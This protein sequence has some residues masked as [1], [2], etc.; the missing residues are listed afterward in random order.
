MRALYTSA[1]GMMAQQ[2]NLDV[3]ANNLA[4]VNT[5]G[6]KRTAAHF[7]DLIYQNL[8]TPGATSD[9]GT[10]L[11][12]GTQVGLG[13]NSGATTKVFTQGTLQSTGNEYDVA[14]KGDGFL[15]VLMPD[16]TTAYTR[17]GALS[18]DS[19]GR[20]VTSDGYAI[21]PEIIIP[22]DKTSVTIGTD[23]TVSVTRQGQTNSEN[24]GQLQ[25][26]RFVNPSGLLA[27]GGNLFQATSA[28]GDPVDDTPG[29]NGLGTILQKTLEAPNVE[30]VEE[31]IRMI[32]VQRAYET[33]SKSVQAS[34]EMLQQANQLKR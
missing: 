29:Q 24:V 13:V 34:D 2:F 1:S 31:M 18:V 32:T 17:D 26:T 27:I 19:Q 30:L 7:Q 14:I 23:G 5:Y 16:G 10:Q 25:L 8:R 20:L 28:S 15:R 6:Y 3:I 9:S 4:N 11:P 22:S 33:N 12:T 21:Q